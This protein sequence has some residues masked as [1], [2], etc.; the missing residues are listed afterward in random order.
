MTLAFAPLAKLLKDRKQVKILNAGS[1]RSGAL[2]EKTAAACLP[3]T[4]ISFVHLD[5]R[6]AEDDG[7]NVTLGDVRDLK[8]NTSAV[9]LQPSKSRSNSSALARLLPFHPQFDPS[10]F[11]AVFMLNA[12][13]AF[14]VAAEAVA[15]FDRVLRPGGYMSIAQDSGWLQDA[16]LSAARTARKANFSIEHYDEGAGGLTV[17]VA[18]I[19]GGGPRATPLRA[20]K[21]PARVLCKALEPFAAAVVYKFLGVYAG[22]HGCLPGTKS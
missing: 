9:T 2:F 20:V 6:L 12:V 14:G 15:Q 5:V 3:D 8:V 16:V 1:G 13:H 11:D 18:R 22:Q 19:P 4:T 17:V 10:S 21:L 7:G